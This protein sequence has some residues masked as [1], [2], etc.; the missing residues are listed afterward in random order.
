MNKAAV[1]QYLSELLYNIL[2]HDLFFAEF[3]N[4]VAESGYESKIHTLLTARLRLLSTLGILVTK[5][6]EFENIGQGL[7]SMHLTGKDF[8]IRI[9]FSF[10]PNGRPVLLLA[11]GEKHGKQKTNYSSHIPPALARLNEFKEEYANGNI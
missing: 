1:N 7:F 10:L 4:L 9:L 8:N 5:A 6:K 2:M 11:F 3:V